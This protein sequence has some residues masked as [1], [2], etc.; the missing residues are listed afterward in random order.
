M[1]KPLT[2]AAVTHQRRGRVRRDC[3]VRQARQLPHVAMARG[4]VGTPHSGQSMDSS[5]RARASA[6]SPD[7]FS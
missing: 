1:A 4:V 3:A 7:R 5:E 6:I 2:G